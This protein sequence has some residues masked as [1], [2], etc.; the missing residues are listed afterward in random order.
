MNEVEK[1]VENLKPHILN[2]EG[3]E[4]EC[5]VNVGGK[6]YRLTGGVSTYG[7]LVVLFATETGKPTFCSMV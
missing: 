5:W 6:T 4:C 7:N 3:K 2:H 1:L